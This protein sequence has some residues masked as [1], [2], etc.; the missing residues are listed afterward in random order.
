MLIIA[1]SEVHHWTSVWAILIW[2]TSY[3][4]NVLL[5]SLPFWIS[6][7]KC[8]IH[9]SSPARVLHVPPSNHFCSVD[10]KWSL[11]IATRKEDVEVQRWSSTNI[12]NAA[13]TRSLAFQWLYTTGLQADSSSDTAS[14]PRWPSETPRRGSWPGATL[15]SEQRPEQ[16]R[17]HSDVTV[18]SL[19]YAPGYTRGVINQS[20]PNPS[21]A[22]WHCTWRDFRLARRRVWRWRSTWWWR[23]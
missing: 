3:L 17:P 18:I 16:H 11:H 14:A 22:T 21:V 8:S 23:Q 12:H 10:L 9:I 15:S 13:I 5:R 4:F 19:T 1:C 20:Q 7:L 6:E 2:Y